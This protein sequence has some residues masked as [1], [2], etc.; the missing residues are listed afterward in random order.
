MIARQTVEA[1][2]TTTDTL[3]FSGTLVTQKGQGDGRITAG[4][5]HIFSNTII[6]EVELGTSRDITASAKLAK[7]IDDKQ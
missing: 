5:R 3:K 7:T 6:T 2:L 1:P 4:W